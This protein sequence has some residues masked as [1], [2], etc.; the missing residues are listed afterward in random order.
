MAG[1]HYNL[2]FALSKTGRRKQAISS[3]KQALLLKP[4]FAEAHHNLAILY[5]EQG[6]RA[7]ALE[8]YSLLKSI[9]YELAQK[10]FAIIYRDKIVN[11]GG[12]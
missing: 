1:A 2:G 3:Y 4:D 6:E 12:R 7:L 9:D 8:Q 5:L 10:L 11:V